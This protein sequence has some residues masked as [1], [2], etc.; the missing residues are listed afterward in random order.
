M[1]KSSARLVLETDAALADDMHF[2][3]VGISTPTL[4]LKLT[5]MTCHMST[6]ELT[7]RNKENII[8]SH[9]MGI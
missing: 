2:Q 9:G 5:R 7:S 8:A 1:S 3:G 6:F 4:L